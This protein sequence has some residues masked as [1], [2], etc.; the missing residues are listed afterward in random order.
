MKPVKKQDCFYFTLH[1]MQCHL[2]NYKNIE[3]ILNDHRIT[4]PDQLNPYLIHGYVDQSN[5]DSKRIMHAWV[6]VGEHVIEYSGENDHVY[7]VN[8]Y[9]ASHNAEEIERFT[10]EEAFEILVAGCSVGFWGDLKAVHTGSPYPTYEELLALDF[11]EMY[12]EE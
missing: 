9:R 2:K 4:P 10:A 3:K 8:S 12:H 6:E 11:Q 7:T 5:G 1:L